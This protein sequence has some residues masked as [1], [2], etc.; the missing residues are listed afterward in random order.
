[1]KREEGKRERRGKRGLIRLCLTFLNMSGLDAMRSQY[2]QQLHRQREGAFAAL[3]E[4]RRVLEEEV[5]RKKQERK[6]ERR[7]K[8]TKKRERRE[9]ERGVLRAVEKGEERESVCVKR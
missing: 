7:K 1:V 3:A 9:R 6:E 4:R 5:S 8:K 2:R